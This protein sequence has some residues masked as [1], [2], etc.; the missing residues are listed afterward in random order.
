M[1]HFGSV[2]S[3]VRIA[4]NDRLNPDSCGYN[5]HTSDQY[6]CNRWHK[7]NIVVSQH[8]RERRAVND[9]WANDHMLTFA[10]QAP[11]MFHLLYHLPR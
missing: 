11:W 7:D 4:S 6:L 3:R 8:T 10:A 9:T 5:I 1:C 2:V